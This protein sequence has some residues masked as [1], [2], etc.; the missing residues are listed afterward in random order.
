MN[1]ATPSATPAATSTTTTT[2]T[3]TAAAA[4]TTTSSSSTATSAATSSAT[5]SF[6]DAATPRPNNQGTA[7][8]RT[9]KSTLGNDFTTWEVGSRYKLQRIL[10]HGSYGEVAQAID[11]KRKAGQPEFVAIKRINGIFDQ[12]I[13]AKR[14]YREMFILRRLR[15]HSCIIRLI[16]VISPASADSFNDLYLVFEYVDTDLY[17]LIMSPQYLSTEHIRHFL[18][19]LLIGLHYIHKSSV[20]HRDLKP[21]NILLNEDCSLKICDFGLARVGESRRGVKHHAGSEAGSQKVWASRHISRHLLA[22]G[23]RFA[24]LRFASLRFASLCFASP[25]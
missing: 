18:Y 8:Q 4:S 6:H 15:A 17:K 1:A 21:A 11:L 23:R 10:G 19:E 13:D 24:S 20:I 7:P 9:A 5:A 12:E 14:I 22:N 16:D 2:T 25:P 3:S